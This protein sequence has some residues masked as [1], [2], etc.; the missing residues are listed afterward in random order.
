M[1]KVYIVGYVYDDFDEGGFSN[2]YVTDSMN[3]AIR[4]MQERDS[5]NLAIRTY[6]LH[7]QVDEY[8]IREDQ[9]IKTSL[10]KER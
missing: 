10:K 8:E 4:Y 2:T 3:D 6:N 7:K 1:K 9:I 5:E